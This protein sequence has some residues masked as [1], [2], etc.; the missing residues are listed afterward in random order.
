MP[1]ACP[2][3]AGGN[4]DN[5]TVCASCSRDIAVPASLIAERDDLAHKR[6]VLQEQLAGAR[7]ELDA[8]KRNRKRRVT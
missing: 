7:R 2:F 3:C 1:T 5:A 4:A 6:D 8:L